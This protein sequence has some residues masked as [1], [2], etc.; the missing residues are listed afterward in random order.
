MPT[1]GRSP[2]NQLDETLK[3][4]IPALVALGKFATLA[5]VALELNLAAVSR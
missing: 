5:E 4:L 3:P 2:S 1:G